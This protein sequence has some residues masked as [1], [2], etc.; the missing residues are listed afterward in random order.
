MYRKETV[1]IR[2]ISLLL[3]ISINVAVNGQ[4]CDSLWNNF[5]LNLQPEKQRNVEF[6][7]DTLWDSNIHDIVL[8]FSKYVDGKIDGYSKCYDLN[9]HL[10][11]IKKFDAGVLNGPT[12]YFFIDES[13]SNEY[14]YSEGKLLLE[15]KYFGNGVLFR[16]VVYIDDK[17][18]YKL[19]YDQNGNLILLSKY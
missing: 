19:E 2:V 15:K 3:F 17:L 5:R 9:C 12:K 8:C 13:L 18:L 11:S 10:V 1:V 16:L 6:S 4:Q 7:V 14:I